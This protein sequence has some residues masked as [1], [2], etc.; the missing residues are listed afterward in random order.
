MAVCPPPGCLLAVS[1]RRQVREET[2]IFSRHLRK[3]PTDSEARL[4]QLLRFKK[5]G[6]KFRRQV[7]IR[8]WIFDFYCPSLSLVIELDG[9]FHDYSLNAKKDAELKR[10]GFT[11]WRYP[12]K[13][14]FDDPSVIINHILTE[15]SKKRVS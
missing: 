10:L 14:V 12:S 15:K 1:L 13:Q 6:V 9:S 11:I 3:N 7:V 4:W 8:G 5:L 2:K